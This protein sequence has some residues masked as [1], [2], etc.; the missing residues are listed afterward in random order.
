MAAASA[1]SED[2]LSLQHTNTKNVLP[3]PFRVHACAAEAVCSTKMVIAQPGA[4][5]WDI[6]NQELNRGQERAYL[7][8][9][10]SYH[11]RVLHSQAGHFSI[12]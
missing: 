1:P 11:L 7:C 5:L 10:P 8:P 6:M 3:L 9:P 2:E 12:A 4:R